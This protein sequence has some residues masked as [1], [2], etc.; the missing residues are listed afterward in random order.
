LQYVFCSDEI[1]QSHA[2]EWVYG[3]NVV[4]GYAETRTQTNRRPTMD[5]RKVSDCERIAESPIEDDREQHN[6]GHQ[7]E[8]QNLIQ[9]RPP[10]GPSPG[11]KHRSGMLP[12][13]KK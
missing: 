1:P 13:E 5:K 2:A 12:N 6:P 3:G 8:L 7:R 10:P 4:T 11:E 9:H